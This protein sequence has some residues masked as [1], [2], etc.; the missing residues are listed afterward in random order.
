MDRDREN[1]IDR[2]R[3][4]YTSIYCMRRKLMNGRRERDRDRDTERDRDR[5]RDRYTS[6]RKN[7]W[8]DRRDT[9]FNIDLKNS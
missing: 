4:I 8:T 6:G 3:D 2:D 9:F 1:T 5:D 7:E